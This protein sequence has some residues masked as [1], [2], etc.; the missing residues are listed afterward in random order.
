MVLA[1]IS[2]YSEPD[3]KML[4]LSSSTLYSCEYL[5]SSNLEVIDAKDIQSIVAM[6]KHTHGIDNAHGLPETR[7]NYSGFARRKD[8]LSNRYYLVEK[9]GLEALQAAGYTEEMEG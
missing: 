5:G 8:M 2:V 6:V 7:V 4:E 9:Q 1:M 3:P